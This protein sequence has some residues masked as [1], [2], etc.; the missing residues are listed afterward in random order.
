MGRFF[1]FIHQEAKEQRG[2]NIYATNARMVVHECYFWICGLEILVLKGQRPLFIFTFQV[3]CA[4][5]LE[6]QGDLCL[7]YL[8][9]A[10]C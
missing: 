2:I 1:C 8:S 3:R 6:E 7:F 10:L 9:S 5:H 4:K